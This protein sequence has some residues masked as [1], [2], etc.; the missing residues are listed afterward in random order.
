MTGEP[1]PS[2]RS[3][4]RRRT[5]ER[6]LQA[7]RSSF[8]EQG[9]EVSLREVARLAGVGIGTLYRHFPTREALLEVLLGHHFRELREEAARLKGT[10]PADEA[11]GKWLRSFALGAA[12]VQGLPASVVASLHDETSQLHAECEAMRAAGADLLA[13]AQQGGAVRRD[14][15][16]TELY[17]LA[18]GVAWSASNVPTDPGLGDRLIDVVLRGIGANAP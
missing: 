9:V 7:A 10:L 1:R 17:V 2:P 3:D 11:L 12:Q 6:L 13:A 8:K 15:T 4:E 14:V 5:H 18:A 16:A